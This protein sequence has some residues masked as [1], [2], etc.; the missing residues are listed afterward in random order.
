MGIR[1]KFNLVLLVVAAIGVGL[2]ALISGP[3]LTDQAREEVLV[4]SRIMMA[5]A[6]GIRKYTAEEIAPLLYVRKNEKFHVQ[7]VAAYAAS[8]NFAVLRSQFPDYNYREAALNPTNLEDRATDSE[9][10]IINDFRANPT[11]T[12]L[13]SERETHAG[14]VLYLSRPLLSSL[15]VG[16]NPLVSHHR[17]PAD[18]DNFRPRHDAAR[19]CS[20]VREPQF[21]V[22]RYCSCVDRRHA[23]V[24]AAHVVFAKGK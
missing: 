1:L 6:T 7:A 12:E 17:H 21:L 18:V 2:F 11:K 3:F 15:P 10:D 20:N 23:K 13:L 16:A 4:R 9:A 19:P 5:G 24:N 8:K 22:A 14:R